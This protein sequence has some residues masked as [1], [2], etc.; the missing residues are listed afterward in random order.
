MTR[1][2]VLTNRHD[3][4]GIQIGIRPLCVVAFHFWRRYRGSLGWTLTFA[5]GRGAGCRWG[6]TLYFSRGAK[7]GQRY[8]YKAAGFRAGFTQ[9]ANETPYSFGS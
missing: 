2:F 6:R 5:F 1:T 8:L 7:G 4:R 9:N 3:Q